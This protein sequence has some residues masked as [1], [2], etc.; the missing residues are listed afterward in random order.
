M[1]RGIIWCPHCGEPHPLGTTVCPTSARSL[2]RSLHRRPEHAPENPLIGAVLAG[3]YRVRRYIGAGGMGEVFEAENHL[4]RRVAVKVARTSASATSLARFEREGVLIA[5]VQHPNICDVYDVGRLPDGR[6]FIVLEHLS[7][8]TLGE[9]LRRTGQLNL[10]LTVDLFA[11]ILS[12]LQAAHGV[13]IVHRDVK[14]A[15]VFLVDRLGCF[16]LVKIVDFGLAKDTS[17]QASTGPGG[18]PNRLTRPGAPL[19][20]YAYMAPEQLRAKPPDGRADLFSVG[21][22][23]YEALTGK[24][25]FA[26]KTTAELQ[27]NILREEPIPPTKL[28]PTLGSGIAEIVMRALQ[29]LPEARFQSAH[30]FQLALFKEF[31]LVAYDSDEVTD[32]TDPKSTT[33]PIV[34]T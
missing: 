22:M 5:A 33:G 16:P 30:A 15:N 32:E 3:R 11:Q 4:G 14:P 21:I 19:G 28:R 2:D 12:A 23:L 24:H 26:G 18:W 7:G 34:V 9:A 1:N 6:P 25:P 20:T 27:A 10:R 17:V 29:K 31:Q 8:E 13:H